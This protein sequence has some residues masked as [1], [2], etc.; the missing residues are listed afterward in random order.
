MLVYLITQAQSSRVEGRH[1]SESK[2]GPFLHQMRRR[3]SVA[4]IRAQSSC[5]LSRLGHFSPGAK[6]AAKG[7][8][9]SKQRE[10]FLAQDHQAHFLA[11]VRGRRIHEEGGAL[12]I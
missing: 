6:H 2:H 10:E 3:L 5:L 12:W 9:I 7:H 8:A 4:I 11:H 1:I